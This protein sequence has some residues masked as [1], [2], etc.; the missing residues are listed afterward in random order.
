[1][2]L[3]F[4]FL[5]HTQKEEEL[6]RNKA[7]ESHVNVSDHPLCN[8][9]MLFSLELPDFKHMKEFDEAMAK[10]NKN[11]NSFLY[12]ND[13]FENLINDAKYYDMDVQDIK[14]SKNEEIVNQRIDEYKK[15]QDFHELCNL[16]DENDMVIKYVVLKN[17][18][19]DKSHMK[20]YDSGAC[21]ADAET[22]DAKLMVKNIIKATFDKPNACSK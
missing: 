13:K 6:I 19:N 4:Q 21:I 14:T 12:T 7:H 10:V 15:T 8:G 17:R 20:I 16:I 9:E 11:V 3:F 18:S 1:M 22:N 5:Q 2:S